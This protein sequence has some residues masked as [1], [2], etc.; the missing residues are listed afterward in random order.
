MRDVSQRQ[1]ETHVLKR[2]IS[3]PV[4]IAPSAMQRMAHPEG[5]VAT[6]KGDGLHYVLCTKILSL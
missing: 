2:K 6:V 4:G 3:F 1:L 5:E